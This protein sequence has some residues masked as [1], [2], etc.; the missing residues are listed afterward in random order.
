MPSITLKALSPT[1]HR[2]LKARAALHKRSLNQEVIASLELI[3]ALN[4]PVDVSAALDRTRSLRER[5]K[6]RA[7]A[8]EVQDYKTAGRR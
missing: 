6:L 4:Q 1:L 7:T 3:V 5:L 8:R 2:K